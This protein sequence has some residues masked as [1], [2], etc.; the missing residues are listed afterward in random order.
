MGVIT[1]TRKSGKVYVVTFSFNG[2][3]QFEPPLKD[4]QAAQRL[5]AQRMREVRNGT[6]RPNARVARQKVFLAEK[7]FDEFIETRRQRQPPVRTVEDDHARLQH[8]VLPLW[9]GRSL[10]EITVDDVRA[11]L[12]A[13]RAKTSPETG[14]PLS[15]NTIRNVFATLSVAMGEVEVQAVTAGHAWRN[16]CK[17]L[18]PTERPHKQRAARG[19][20]RRHEAEALMSDPRIPFERR[21]FWSVLFFTGMR[22]DEAAGVRFEDIEWDHEPL[23]RLVLRQQAD[24][25]PLKEDKR[26]TGLTREIPIHPTLARVLS[27]WRERGFQERFG[28]APSPRDWLSPSTMDVSAYRPTRTSLKQIRTD[29]ELVGVTPRTVHETRNT[30]LT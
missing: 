25:S 22:H 15:A 29:A 12:A 27:A 7:F 17:L 10:I 26:S 4:K 30:F 18:R 21:V 1:R 23:A 28:R 13:L 5:Y 16:P 9:R 19:Y 8:H 2:K 6:Y 20:Y 3:Q 24:G 14:R 11:L